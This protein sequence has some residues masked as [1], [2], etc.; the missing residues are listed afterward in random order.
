[1]QA[2]V[3]RRRGICGALV[4]QLG[5]LAEGRS[6][7]RYQQHDLIPTLAQWTEPI[8]LQ[9]TPPSLAL[10]ERLAAEGGQPLPPDL[11][12]ARQRLDAAI[13]KLD[14]VDFKKWIA[15]LPP[16]FD[17]YFEFRLARRLAEQRDL[18]SPSIRLAL[19]ARAWPRKR[20]R[21]PWTA[22][23]GRASRSSAPTA[24]ALP[25]SAACWEECGPATPQRRFNLLKR[26]VAEYEQAAAWN[27]DVVALEHLS[28]DS[29][30][31]LPDYLRW[32]MRSIPDADSVAPDAAAI[33]RLVGELEQALG[34]LDRPAAVSLPDVRRLRQELESVS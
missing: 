34:L 12:A 23:H 22:D 2:T 33:H 27:G 25:A 30:F 29:L 28:S 24:S 16:K 10:A 3:R 7:Q 11:L 15:E 8:R 4:R 21:K 20:P 9:A 1:M 17:E 31:C 18:D 19:K 13:D 6:P 14:L 5:D 26:A 32:L